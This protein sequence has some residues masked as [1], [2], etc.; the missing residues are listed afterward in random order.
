VIDR[1]PRQACGNIQNDDR[2]SGIGRIIGGK[3]GRLGDATGGSSA[4][5]I[6]RGDR[7]GGSKI[8]P[9]TAENKA[10]L[11]GEIRLVSLAEQ[12]ISDRM[13]IAC[14]PRKPLA[15]WPVIEEQW[16][17]GHGTWGIGDQGI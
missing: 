9:T 1:G 10:N 4:G 15:H 2:E 17:Q 3:R 7:Q 5:G 12:E 13:S 16:L 8:D 14:I 6:R 11:N